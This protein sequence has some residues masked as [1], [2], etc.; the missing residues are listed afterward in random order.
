MNKTLERER[1]VAREILGV[2]TSPLVATLFVVPRTLVDQ[3]VSE[4]YKFTDSGA[5]NII[6]ARCLFLKETAPSRDRREEREREKSKRRRIGREAAVER[7]RERER[8][9]IADCKQAGLIFHL[10]SPLQ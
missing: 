9:K 2:L 1:D 5:L 6:V 4:I 3:T 8:E 7:E 10:L